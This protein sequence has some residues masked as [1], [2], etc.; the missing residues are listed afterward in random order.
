MSVIRL[1]VTVP[2]TET[3]TKVS[4]TLLAV[5]PARCRSL[6]ADPKL[7]K[8]AINRWNKYV[9]AGPRVWRKDEIDMGRCDAWH[10]IRAATSL[11]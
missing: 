2:F 9:E 3:I 4:P 6:R 10:L 5:K 7:K 11:K 8:T 1:S